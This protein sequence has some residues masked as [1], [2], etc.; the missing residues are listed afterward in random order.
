[1][2]RAIGVFVAV[3]LAAIVAPACESQ[4]G[5]APVAMA[6]PRVWRAAVAN[7]TV[8]IT[9]LGHASFEIVSPGGVSA[10][11]DYNGINVPFDPP[12]I[13]TMNHAHS[14]HYTLD[15]DPRIPHVLH[16]WAENGQMAAFDLT[17][18]D[19]HVTNLPTN[20]RTPDG[21]TERYGNS[22][23]VF[24]AGGL[25]IAHLSH[26][27]HLL[28][29]ADIATLGHVDIVMVAVDGIWTMSQRDAASVVE[30]LQ[31]RIVLPMHYFTRGVLARFL[32][33]ERGKY[34]I[35]MRDNPVLEISRSTLPSTPTVIALPGWD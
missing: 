16:G 23:F 33:L 1:M 28:E 27:H 30:Q 5:C 8:Q 19:M 20:I 6:A 31:P 18:Q 29:P 26:L 22:I 35:D 10:V 14:T 4:A 34:A 3:T 9:F 21:E 7:D 13:A 25:C 17:V 12:D 15:P 32:D 11:T 2:P 24:E